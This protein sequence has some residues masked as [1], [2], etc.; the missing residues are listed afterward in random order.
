MEGNIELL[1]EE[2]VDE[3]KALV[4]KPVDEN[5]LVVL[6]DEEEGKALSAL[7]VGAEGNAD[8]G[9]DRKL[10]G[11]AEAD[12]EVEDDV[13]KAEKAGTGVGEKGEGEVEGCAGKGALNI[14]AAGAAPNGGVAVAVKPALEPTIPPATNGFIVTALSGW[15][16]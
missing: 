14:D 4:A 1:D 10:E 2:T 16:I 13:P 8:I 9:V 7:A 15:H 12:E 5:T 3:G 6:V 11:K